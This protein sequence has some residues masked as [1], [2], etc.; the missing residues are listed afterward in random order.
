MLSTVQ[1]PDRSGRRRDARDDSAEIL[2]Q[3]FLQEALVNSCGMQGCPPCDV[4]N[5]A[6]PLP[7]TASHTL[8]SALKDG[9][10][11]AVMSSDM[12][13]PCQFPSLDSCQKRFLWTHKEVDLASHQVVG[14]VVQ[15]GDAEKF[16][17]VLGF[18]A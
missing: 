13:E 6:F 8:Q 11:D 15:L 16:P 2:F 10:G 3:A 9:F 17:Q 12:P 5:P 14:R 4:F 1:S 7:T 18:E